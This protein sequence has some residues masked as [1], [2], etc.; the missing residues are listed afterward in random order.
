MMFH[1]ILITKAE[2]KV[3]RGQSKKRRRLVFAM[4]VLGPPSYGSANVRRSRI[5]HSQRR[6]EDTSLD[7]DTM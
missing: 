2:T 3:K 5:I 7:D 6:V 4:I 1:H